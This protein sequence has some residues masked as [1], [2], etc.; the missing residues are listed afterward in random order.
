MEYQKK[1]YEHKLKRIEEGW[2]VC[3]EKRE[4]L[5]KYRNFI[6]PMVVPRVTRKEN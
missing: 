3:G 5:T 2:E 1:E 4:Q 6:P